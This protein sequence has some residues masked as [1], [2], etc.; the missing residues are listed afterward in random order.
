MCGRFGGVVGMVI[1]NDRRWP[2]TYRVLG[3]QG[4]EM[5]LI[6]YNTPDPQPARTRAGPLSAASTTS[7]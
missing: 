1:C 4:V 6:G 7:W 2:E 3:L 5:I